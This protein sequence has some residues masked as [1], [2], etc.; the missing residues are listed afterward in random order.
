MTQKRRNPLTPERIQLLDSIGFSWKLRSRETLHEFWENKYNQLQEYQVEHGHCRVPY[1]TDNSSLFYWCETQRTQYSLFVKAKNENSDTSEC[2]AITEEQITKLQSL[3][4]DFSINTEEIW[5]KQMEQL[6]MFKS[7]YGRDCPVPD[8]YSENPSLSIFANTQRTQM[9]L[10]KQGKMSTL[11]EEKIKELDSVGFCWNNAGQ[12]SHLF[13]Q[14]T[15]MKEIKDGNAEQTMVG[16]T[17]DTHSHAL[18]HDSGGASGVP[19]A[20]YGLLYDETVDMNAIASDTNNP[21]PLIPTGGA[22]DPS[23]GATTSYDAITMAADIA[24]ASIL[25]N[26][27]NDQGSNCSYIKTE[28]DINYGN[29]GNT[30]ESNIDINETCPNE[31]TEDVIFAI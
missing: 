28:E 29:K 18:S 27:Y 17:Y 24:A 5:R 12:K 6:R 10:Y 15:P 7:T 23:T 16:I 3:G 25:G 1:T 9:A 19:T 11:D 13:E 2:C 31:E 26:N 20:N 22:I 4:F 30:N 14:N 21:M 8:Y